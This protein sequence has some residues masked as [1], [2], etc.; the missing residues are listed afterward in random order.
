MLLPIKHV[1]SSLPYQQATYPKYDR[2]GHESP[3]GY[4]PLVRHTGFSLWTSGYILTDFS[5]LIE[6]HVLSV[7]QHMSIL[8]RFC[9]RTDTGLNRSQ[10][11][12]HRKQMLIFP[13]TLCDD[14]KSPLSPLI[15]LNHPSHRMALDP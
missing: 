13:C 15:V 12:R 9:P 1:H 11:S 4:G 2:R 7:Y 14:L 8:P 5:L 6:R 10:A 3:S